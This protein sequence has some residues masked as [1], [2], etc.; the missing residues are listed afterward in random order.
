MEDITVWFETAGISGSPTDSVT[1]LCQSIIDMSECQ[2]VRVS[3]WGV[4][5]QV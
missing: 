4:A 2:S 3:E 5:R 1:I